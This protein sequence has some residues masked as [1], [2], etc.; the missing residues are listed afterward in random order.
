MHNKSLVIPEISS[1]NAQIIEEYLANGHNKTQA[2]LKVKPDSAYSGCITTFNEI[3]ARPEVKLYIQQRQAELQ[4]AANIKAIDI[5]TTLKQWVYA[6]ATQ[7]IGLTKDEI[8]QLPNEVKQ[9]IQS[10]DIKRKSYTNRQGQ[11]ITEETIKLNLVSKMDAIE[12]I[13]KHLGFYEAHN[14]QK[15]ANINVLLQSFAKDSPDAAYKLLQAI[16]TEVK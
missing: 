16:T 8:Q 7:L 4:E 11:E 10:V 6:D 14:Q 15:G 12:K 1:S 9:C 3:S 2:I 5:L 13:N